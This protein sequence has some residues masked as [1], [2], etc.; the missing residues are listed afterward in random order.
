MEN[1]YDSQFKDYRDIDQEERTNY[2]NNKL[3]KITK[4]KKSQKLNLNDDV[5]MDYDPTSLYPRAMWDEN[6]VY[7]KIGSGFAFK[8]HMNDVHVAFNIQSFYQDVNESAILKIKYYNPP[9]LIFQ[10]LPVKEKVK[11]IKINRM[12]NGHI[13]DTLTSVDIQEVV[14]IG[15]KVIEIYE[16]VTH[17]ENFKISP[18]R[19]VIEK[20]FVL[21]QKYKDAGNDLMQKLVKL[22]MN[23]LYGV[24]IR[25]DIDQFY[26]C[27]SEHWM[28]TEYDEGY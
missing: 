17:R 3:S 14:K 18:F 5:M 19:K 9:N 12:R 15:G 22:I 8:P 13:I 4:H 16:G 20:L 23:S 6:S 25:K 21:R 11:N 7:P 10:H 2:I 27:K 24:Q 1:E 26:K 28:Q